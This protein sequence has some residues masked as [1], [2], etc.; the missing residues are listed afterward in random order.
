MDRGYAAGKIAV[1]HLFKTC[2]PYHRGEAILIGEFADALHKILIGVF[3]T[4]YATTERGNG[5]QGI[6]LIDL[7]QYRNIHMGELE[8]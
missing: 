8:T 6:L 1:A 5:F 7:I 3:I 2:I 4:S